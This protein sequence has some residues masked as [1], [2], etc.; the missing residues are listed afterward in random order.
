M[1]LEKHILV[2]LE[3][4]RPDA[5][6]ESVLR[7]EL[8]IRLRTRPGTEATGEALHRLRRLGY[9]ERKTDELTD[10]IRWFAVTPK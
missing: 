5:L 6:S 8:A 1:T 9:I 10:D 7:D 3:R 4:I 2:V